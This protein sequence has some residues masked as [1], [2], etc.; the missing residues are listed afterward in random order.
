MGGFQI[1]GTRSGLGKRDWA[2][3]YTTAEADGLLRSGDEGCLQLVLTM[4]RL[5]T[6]QQQPSGAA[7]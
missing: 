1:N 4:E 2:F 5:V 6:K 3:R 7:G